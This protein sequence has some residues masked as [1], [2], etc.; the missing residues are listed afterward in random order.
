MNKKIEKVSLS[1][2]FPELKSSMFFFPVQTLEIFESI[3]S[4]NNSNAEGVDG[5]INKFLSLPSP[6]LSE[7]L[8]G[9][10]GSKV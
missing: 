1:A 2:N 5:I 9:F 3:K 6:I 4:L 8:F 7:Q 10:F